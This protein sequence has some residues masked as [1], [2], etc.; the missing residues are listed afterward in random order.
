M[1]ER[2]LE[3]EPV[4]GE[5][6]FGVG[7]VVNEFQVIISVHRLSSCTTGR[8]LEWNDKVCQKFIGFISE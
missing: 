8:D 1:F 3:S 6:L 5:I 4:G 7:G 2:G